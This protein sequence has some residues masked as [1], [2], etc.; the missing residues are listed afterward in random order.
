MIVKN[1]I[2]FLTLMTCN[3]LLVCCLTMINSTLG[4]FG[5]F[6]YLPGLLFLQTGLFLGTRQTLTLLFLTGLLYDHSVK[7]T[8][9][10]HGL[11]LCFSYLCIQEIFKLGK[12][13][14]FGQPLTVQ[15]SLNLIIGIF[16]LAFSQISRPFSASWGIG[17]AILD[18][19]ISTILIIPIG[20]WYS[21]FCKRLIMKLSP[22]VH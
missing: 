11:C 19:T 1:N 9:G 13:F 10:F 20:A 4:T 3:A 2:S 21:S 12:D 22:Q 15:V 5:L 17:Q 8:F 18:L 14:K 6:L 7:S 16:W